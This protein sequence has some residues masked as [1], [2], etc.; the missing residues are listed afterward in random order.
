MDQR[1]VR[2]H[3]TRKTHYN[4]VLASRIFRMPIEGFP[5]YFSFLTLS[6][7]KELSYLLQ[8]SP[9]SCFQS[10]LVQIFWDQKPNYFIRTKETDLLKVY[11]SFLEAGLIGFIT[12]KSDS[13]REIFKEMEVQLVFACTNTY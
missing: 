8:S 5:P 2:N 3:F 13:H 12:G 10:P 9:G 4:G 11:F 1:I 6:Q 7:S